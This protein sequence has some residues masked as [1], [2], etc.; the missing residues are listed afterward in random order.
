MDKVDTSG[1]DRRRGTTKKAK[2]GYEHQ[3][4]WNYPKA[5]VLLA[6]KQIRKY[7]NHSCEGFFCSRVFFSVFD[8]C[9]VVPE[10]ADARI[11]PIK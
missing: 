6:R 10:C 11:F 8:L 2:L 3:C 4:L 5:V 7:T 9:G 1:E